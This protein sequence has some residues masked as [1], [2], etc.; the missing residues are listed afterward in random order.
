MWELACTVCKNFLTRK[1]T[2]KK[3]NQDVDRNW[4]ALRLRFHRK[5]AVC[6]AGKGVEVHGRPEDHHQVIVGSRMA[7]FLVPI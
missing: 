6:Q 2:D 1:R 7:M 4:Q 3:W 5:G